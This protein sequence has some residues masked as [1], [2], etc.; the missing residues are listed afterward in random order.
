ML[1]A[2]STARGGFNPPPQVPKQTAARK[3]VRAG[4][5]TAAFA[6]ALRG[7]AAP[8]ADVKVDEEP[9]VKDAYR[10]IWRFAEHKVLARQARVMRQRLAKARRAYAKCAT[11]TQPSGLQSKHALKTSADGRRRR[12][13]FAS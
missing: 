13:K 6:E 3:R 9:N 1:Q 7:D 8:E 5:P 12:T 4:A 2:Y 11:Q 10:G